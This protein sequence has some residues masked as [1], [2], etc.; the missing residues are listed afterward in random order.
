MLPRLISRNSTQHVQER[1]VLVGRLPHPHTHMPAV[2]GR[3]VGLHAC[4]EA[5]RPLLC[6]TL[7]PRLQLGAQPT[8]HDMQ[9]LPAALAHLCHLCNVADR[10][11]MQQL[12]VLDIC[13]VRDPVL[14]AVKDVCRV[15]DCR[16]ALLALSA[17]EVK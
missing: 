1:P 14:E 3:A 9:Q 10:S 2:H 15:Q 6:V 11:A 7:A 4:L 17:E 16:A 8:L 13:D 12:P 5:R